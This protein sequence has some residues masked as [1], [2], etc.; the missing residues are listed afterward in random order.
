[1]NWHFYIVSVCLALI[2]CNGRLSV[3]NDFQNSSI[4]EH[5]DEKI[6]YNYLDQPLPGEIPEIFAPGIVSTEYHDDGAP[7]LSPDGN[8]IYFRIVGKPVSAIFYCKRING[9]WSS[10]Q[11]TSFSGDYHVGNVAFC[12][13]GRRLYFSTN[14]PKEGKNSPADFNIWYIEK[15]DS[16]WRTPIMLKNAINS[17]NDELWI[18]IGDS[19]TIYFSRTYINEK[20]NTDIFYSHFI[21]NRFDEI[22]SICPIIN[23]KGIETAPT[24]APDESY[25]IFT[26]GYYEGQNPLSLFITF[27]QF[28]GGWGTPIPLLSIMQRSYCDKFSGLSPDG[29]YLFWVSQRS[30]SIINP[31]RNWNANY[32]TS[33]N[34][35]NGCDIYWVSTSFISDIKLQDEI[36]KSK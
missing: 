28:D 31:L 21:D 32:F 7:T 10:P 3:D 23:S 33:N 29:K 35:K 30:S 6:E 25:L 22:N 15:E 18:D 12:P 24:I 11:L 2:S 20:N 16:I 34:I 13:D 4:S 27:K 5:V 14:R 36:S 19:G 1:M 26:A 9:T 8:E 17:P